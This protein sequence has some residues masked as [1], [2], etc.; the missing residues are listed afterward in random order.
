MHIF[1]RGG[2]RSA[3]TW[4]YI[5]INSRVASISHQTSRPV[6][7]ET[8]SGASF[9]FY[10]LIGSDGVG[11][12]VWRA[13]F[14]SAKPS[15][16]KNCAYRAVIPYSQI[17]KDP[18]LAETVLRPTIEVWMA[19]HAYII[20]Y[21]IS[22][23]RDFNMVLSH[24]RPNPVTSVEDV[25]MNDLRNEYRDFDPRIRKTINIIPT[26]KRW[27]LLVTGP[28]NTWSSPQKNVVL[29]GDAATAWQTT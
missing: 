26:A 13:L 23:G 19:P 20:T 24:H 5:H 21:P 29:M 7:A 12:I 6:L 1:I 18:F 28:L 4:L 22:A 11:S 15:P 8:E 16:P 10:R 17:R 9:S 25:D 2:R 27:P 14:P 3:K